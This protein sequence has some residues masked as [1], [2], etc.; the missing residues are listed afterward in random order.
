MVIQKDF[1]LSQIL[2]YKIGGKAGFL[3][4]CQSVEDVKEAL[5]FIAK[6]KIEKV[7]VVGLGSNLIIPDDYFNGAIIR[8]VSNNESGK[9]IERKGDCVT[10]FAGIILDQVI[11]FS[12][13]NELTGLEWAG[14]LPG[15]VGAGVR[16][17][18]GAFGKEIKDS[19]HSVVVL[20]K[21]NNEYI[22][23]TL[24][25]ADLN[26]S[27]RNSLIKENKNM[28]VAQATFRLT[29]SDPAGVGKAR[30]TYA[31]NIAYRAKNH[32]MEYPT[33]GSVFKNISDP[34]QIKQILAAWPD[35]EETIKIKWHGKVSM[36]YIINRLGLSGRRSGNMQIS[37]KHANFIV[38]TG[39]GK[40]SDVFSLIEDIK[41]KMRQ[42]FN[43]TPEV[44][45][46]I[47]SL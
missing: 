17:N 12:F 40:A 16:G 27:Y 33:C 26:F 4:D 24:S 15:T 22:T 2:W 19:L 25:N 45:A 9:S 41:E 30:L 18:V 28:I 43:F 32:P 38:N 31:D 29:P 13:A 35:I 20:E 6:N 11:R 21:K 14:G 5:E 1:L 7:L 3:L 34:N 8:I 44:E 42:T 37:D 47:V 23:H 10:V 46:E 36:G 39:N